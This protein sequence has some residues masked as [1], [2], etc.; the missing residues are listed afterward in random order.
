[1]IKHWRAWLNMV[2]QCLSSLLFCQVAWPSIPRIAEVRV[3]ARLL[4]VTFAAAANE[5]QVGLPV[6]A[7]VIAAALGRQAHD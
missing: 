3:P 2:C 6:K 4:A 1:M 5:T 7:R